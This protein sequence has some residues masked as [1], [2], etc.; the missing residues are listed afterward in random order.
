MNFPKEYKFPAFATILIA[1]LFLILAGILLFTVPVLGYYALPFFALFGI[2]FLVIIFSRFSKT[3]ITDEGITTSGLFGSKTLNWNEIESVSG[4]G[5]GIKLRNAEGDVSVS[6]SPHLPGYVEVIEIIG[7]K[8]P[9]LFRPADEVVFGR[10]WLNAI[11]VLVVG[12]VFLIGSVWMYFDAAPGE[13]LMPILFVGFVVLMLFVFVFLSI[14][15]IKLEGRTMTVRYLLSGKTYTATE[16][17]NMSMNVMQTRNGKSYSIH[18][19]TADNR[20]IRFSGLRPSLPIV[21][22]TL[23]TWWRGL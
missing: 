8:R 18:I 13:T 19:F 15:Y 21:Y 22:L 5:Y 7:S 11:A 12:V 6:P 2:M 20:N 4:S 17:R 23:R 9:D 16:I 14:L 3:V 1:V 10:N